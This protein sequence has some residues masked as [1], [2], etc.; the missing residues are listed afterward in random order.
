VKVTAKSTLADVAVAV[1]DALRRAGIRG[2]LTG[3]ASAHLYAEGA[4][5][6]ADVDFVLAE[7]PTKAALD[8]AMA[9]LGFKRDR[10]RYIHSKTSYY[11]EFPRGPL[12]IGEDFSIRP[13][14]RSRHGAR[15]LVLSATDACRDR[16][17]AYFHWNDRQSLN[18][19][20]AIAIRN[21]VSLAKIRQ[22]SRKEGYSERFGVFTAELGRERAAARN[23]RRAGRS[24]RR[25]Q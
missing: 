9:P 24:R 12:G 22:W 14:W 4:Y 2:V 13:V 20:V 23:R 16:L 25:A 11:V 6:S 15:T 19:A 5:T 8:V 17:A 10:D 3:G 1:G 7:P 18:V 21:R